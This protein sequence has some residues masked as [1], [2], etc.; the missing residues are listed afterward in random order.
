MR[1]VKALWLRFKLAEQR[2]LL[3]NAIRKTVVFCAV[4]MEDWSLQLHGST[5]Y[6]P[7]YHLR[8]SCGTCELLSAGKYHTL[9]KLV[10]EGMA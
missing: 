4:C 3:S 7:I 1:I 10:T 5:V 6:A 2:L 9:L 8:E